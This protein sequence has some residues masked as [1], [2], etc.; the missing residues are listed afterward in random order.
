MNMGLSY[1]TVSGGIRDWTIA[2][3]VAAGV[4]IVLKL[5]DF[6]FTR[7]LRKFAERGS[8]GEMQIDASLFKVNTKAPLILLI[9]LYV[10]SLYLTLPDEVN[11]VLAT[12]AM[13]AVFM[14]VGFWA[15][16][17]LIHWI[18]RRAREKSDS[19]PGGSSALSIIKFMV[20]LG[21]WTI[22]SVLILDNLGVDITAVV[23]GLGIG[24][25]A[26]ALAVQN[27][28]GDLF[29]SISI[30]IDKPFVIGDFIIVDD[31]MGTVEHVGIKTTRLRSLSGEQL[32]FSNADLLGSRI[33]NFKR[34][35]ER[36]VVFKFGVTYDTA[37]EKLEAIPGMV[38]EIIE[39]LGQTRFDRSHFFEYG[40]SSLVFETVYYVLV[41]DYNVYMD[42]Q[43][44][45][46]LEISRRFKDCGIEFAYPTHTV[47][48][49]GSKK[50]NEGKSEK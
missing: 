8:D 4:Y 17:A 25:V 18:S 44:A 12:V 33:R 23:A 46:N 30:A 19:D 22:V 20:K 47:Y 16:G 48:I 6:L 41:A 7:Y 35:Y 13:V 34:M 28:L 2:I 32:V 15:D 11:K 29:A 21:L 49:A 9:S 27:I 31:L 37:V 45:V 38:K 24:G 50:K 39:S 1:L 43:Q 3:C 36:R 40:D 26:V 5:L 42:K 14:Q 10:G